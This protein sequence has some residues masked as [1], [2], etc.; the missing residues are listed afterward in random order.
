[1]IS[2]SRT[3]CHLFTLFSAA[4]GG[5]GKRTVRER[6]YKELPTYYPLDKVRWQAKDPWHKRMCRRQG[7]SLEA[8]LQRSRVPSSVCLSLTQSTVGSAPTHLRNSL[9]PRGIL[10]YTIFWRML[11]R[12]FRRKQDGCPRLHVW[13]CKQ[14][15]PI[16][17]FGISWNQ[18]SD[19]LASGVLEHFRG[20]LP[21]SWVTVRFLVF[22]NTNFNVTL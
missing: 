16:L 1:M 10:V 17:Y 12:V 21:V 20:A 18:K 22:R 8:G 14:Q 19:A 4:S 6:N 13:T 11:C 3:K 2:F 15:L 5:I 7:L 9:N